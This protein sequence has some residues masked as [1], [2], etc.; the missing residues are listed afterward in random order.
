MNQ[1][2]SMRALLSV[3]DQGGF[4]PAAQALS[5]SR[6]KVTRLIQDLEAALNI[7]LL[8]RTTRTLSLTEAGEVYV[9]RIRPLIE[10]L[11]AANDEA[12]TSGRMPG[13]LLKVQSSLDFAAAQLIPRVPRLQRVYPRLEIE[14]NTSDRHLEAP[15][16]KADVTVLF[17]RQGLA[18]GDYTAVKLG[19]TH[20][21]LCASPR[22]LEAH[23][24]PAHPSE[25]EQHECL[26]PKGKGI[27]EVLR[28]RST[29]PGALPGVDVPGVDVRPGPA[30][31][32]S[33]SP[34]ALYM[35]ALQ[36]MGVIGMLSAHAQPYLQSGALVRVLPDWVGDSWQVWLAFTGRKHV[37]RKV[38]AFLAFL[39]SEFG[40]PDADPWQGV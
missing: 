6:A 35:A 18:D 27:A 10:G 15:D 24:A 40:D 4:A 23:P 30:R 14:I 31:F 26:F 13:G 3:V 33:H 9:A 1:L 36:G 16:L 5:T 25:L 28:F 22:Y 39:K 34:E 38:Q 29:A 37:P 19:T 32:H 20:A 12:S 17:S 7:R 2:D 21:L 11:D 8:Q